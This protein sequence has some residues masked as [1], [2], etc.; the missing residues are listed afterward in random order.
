MVNFL[1]GFLAMAGMMLMI[2]VIVM[3]PTLIH[4]KLADRSRVVELRKEKSISSQKM[5]S[6]VAP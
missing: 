4:A 1:H 6:E 5:N 3:N 2:L